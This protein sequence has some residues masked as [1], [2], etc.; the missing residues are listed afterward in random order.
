MLK[1]VQHDNNKTMK[2]KTEII[3]EFLEKSEE[4]LLRIDVRMG[5]VQNK[6]ATD[7]KKHYMEELM[8][9]TADKN[10]T[11]EWVAYLKTQLAKQ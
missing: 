11:E 5:F 1:Q 7:N 4:S 8:Q 9:L 3:K 2:T 10:E 6:Y